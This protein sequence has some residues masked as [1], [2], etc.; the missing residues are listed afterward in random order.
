VVR[1]LN[2]LREVRGVPQ[3]LFGDNGAQFSSHLLP[4]REMTEPRTGQELTF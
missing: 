4:S 1:V 3:L 2:R